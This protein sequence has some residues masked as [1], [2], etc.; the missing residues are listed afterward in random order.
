MLMI[1]GKSCNYLITV[2]GKLLHRY[3]LRC[4]W[5][6]NPSSHIH[7]NERRRIFL[8]DNNLLSALKR[9]FTKCQWSF[10]ANVSKP[11]A[12][13]SRGKGQ[14]TKLNFP[15]EKYVILQV[16]HLIYTFFLK[17]ILMHSSMLLLF[18]YPNIS[19]LELKEKRDTY[20]NMSSF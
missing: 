5:L 10:E 1:I 7:A 8:K 14:L 9:F 17:L 15:Q 13:K 11:D 6:G 20:P 4:H 18:I 2:H 3:K 16:I 19:R 12:W